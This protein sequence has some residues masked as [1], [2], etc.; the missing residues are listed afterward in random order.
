MWYHPSTAQSAQLILVS[1]FFHILHLSYISYII[2]LSLIPPKIFIQLCSF[3]G[4]SFIQST[5][6]FLISPGTLIIMSNVMF[7]FSESNYSIYILG[8]YILFSYAK[9]HIYLLLSSFFTYN[10]I[11]KK[12]HVS[13][14]IYSIYSCVGLWL[15]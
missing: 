11:K 13:Y 8:I 4:E 2:N 14:F 3:W 6:G 1:C 7:D 10:H 9:W 5:T 12:I 15:G